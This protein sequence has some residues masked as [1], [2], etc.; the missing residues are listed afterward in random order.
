M[1]A[2]RRHARIVHIPPARR[3]LLSPG[4]SA[5]GPGCHAPL[6]GGE[7]PSAA[8]C[9]GRGA[10]HQPM[11]EG[12]CSAARAEAM[13]AAAVPE[14]TV[15]GDISRQRRAF[16][17]TEGARAQHLGQKRGC[18][19]GTRGQVGWRHAHPAIPR[20]RPS[21]GCAGTPVSTG[22]RR[23]LRHAT[24]HC[25]ESSSGSV[26]IALRRLAGGGASSG[27][28]GAHPSASR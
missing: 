1:R 19:R 4:L 20:W 18:T 24:E 16:P 28:Q 2:Q 6:T 26:G 7:G 8:V 23:R 21:R 9:F 11:P 13:Q 15:Q 22:R 3:V 17:L 12:A 10:R 27:A 5:Q 25:P 14:G